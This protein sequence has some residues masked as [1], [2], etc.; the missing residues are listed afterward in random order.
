MLWIVFFFKQGK[1]YRVVL[2]IFLEEMLRR[3]NRVNERFGYKKNTADT[4]FKPNT[5]T[6]TKVLLQ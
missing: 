1:T 6:N 4:N 5:S 2:Q 3:D